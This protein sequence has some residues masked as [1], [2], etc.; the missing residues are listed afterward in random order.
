MNYNILQH[1]CLSARHV[2]FSVPG[3]LHNIVSDDQRVAT[4]FKLARD[5]KPTPDRSETLSLTY[6]AVLDTVT[7]GKFPAA[8]GLVYTQHALH[9]L[10]HIDWLAVDEYSGKLNFNS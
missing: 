6:W 4:T 5:T 2:D 9:R 1:L 7:G 10:R 8:A 3:L